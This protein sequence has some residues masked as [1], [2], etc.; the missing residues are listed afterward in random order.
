M[1]HTPTITKEKIITE[2]TQIE[3][4]DNENDC[5]EYIESHTELY[6]FFED[7]NAY[8]SKLYIAA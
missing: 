6:V 4:F 7:I 2:N 3:F 1:V 8:Y 5:R